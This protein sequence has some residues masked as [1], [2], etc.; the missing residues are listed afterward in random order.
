MSEQP[1]FGSRVDGCPYVVR[2][3]AYAVV[4]DARGY[5][6]IVHTAQGFRVPTIAI[7]Y[8]RPPGTKRVGSGFTVDWGDGDASEMASVS[9]DDRAIMLCQRS[10]GQPGTWLWIGVEDIEPLFKEL[11]ARVRRFD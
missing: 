5:I 10:Q 4:R 7:R 11:S 2:P 6:A 3:S 1:E 9:R 8:S